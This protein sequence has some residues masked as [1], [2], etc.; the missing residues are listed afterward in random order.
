M[1]RIVVRDVI[2]T[3][4]AVSTDNGLKVFHEIDNLLKT[5]EKIDLDFEGI[6]VVITAFL[7]A[8]IGSLYKDGVY[9]GEFLNNHLK[10]RN[11]DSNDLSL[12]K[13]VIQ[14][15]KEYF[16]NKDSFEA[17]SN[18]SIYGKN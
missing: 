5:E 15:A 7:N 11:V 16:S 14:R 8:A 13:D 4:L 6:T 3:N 17:N 9:S 18:K 10:L 1:K 2:G 12:F